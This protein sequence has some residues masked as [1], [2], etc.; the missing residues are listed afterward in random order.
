M[1]DKANFHRMGNLDAA[2][3]IRVLL[4][5]DDQP[6]LDALSPL[7]ERQPAR[8]LNFRCDLLEGAVQKGAGRAQPRLG[9]RDLRLHDIVVA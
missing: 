4:A 3:M 1:A 6:F 8:A 5:D 7:I 2:A 9:L